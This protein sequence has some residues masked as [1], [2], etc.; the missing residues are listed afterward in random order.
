MKTNNLQS[1][2]FESGF[3][4]QGETTAINGFKKAYRA[5]YAK[6]YNKDYDGKTKRKTLIFTPEEF[7]YL[8]AQAK[9]YQ[10]KLSPFLKSLIFAYLN[11]SFISIEQE[12]LT[13]IEAQLREMNRRVSESVQYI[14]LSETINVNDIQSLKMDIA[15]L[16]KA[17][18]KS[19]Q[20]PPR[21]ETWLESQIQKDE[22]F[23][24]KLLKAIAS[25]LNPNL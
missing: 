6:D 16:E 8:E 11:A 14:H 17:L 7:E 23:L 10:T 3:I 20:H 24:P 2:L 22:L 13:E 9:H 12:T 19:L 25:F 5:A 4:E 18:S 15:E 21:L 1:K